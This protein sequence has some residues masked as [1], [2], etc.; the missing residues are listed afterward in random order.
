MTKFDQILKEQVISIRERLAMIEEVHT[1]NFT[2]DVTGRVHDG[3]IKIEYQIGSPYSTGGAVKGGNI[4][5]VLDE[6]MR[7]FGW[8]KRNAPLMISAVEPET[9]PEP[10]H[11]DDDIPF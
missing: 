8:D 11:A 2:I 4:D 7:R 10:I 3:E 1:M 6:Y 9:P 5:F